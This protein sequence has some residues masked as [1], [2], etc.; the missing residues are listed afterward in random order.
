MF[1][2]SLTLTPCL[3]FWGNSIDDRYHNGRNTLQ[4]SCKLYAIWTKS[5]AIWI[6]ARVSFV[7]GKYKI[8]LSIFK[9]YGLASNLFCNGQYTVTDRY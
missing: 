1:L 9:L 3:P 8:M 2:V 6:L 4:L 5:Y 7:G